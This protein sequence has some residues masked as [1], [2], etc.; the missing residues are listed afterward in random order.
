MPKDPS[1]QMEQLENSDVMFTIQ[2]TVK[3]VRDS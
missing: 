1:V 3:L 2:M